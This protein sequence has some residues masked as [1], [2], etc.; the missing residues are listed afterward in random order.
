MVLR[1]TAPFRSAQARTG[2]SPLPASWTLTCLGPPENSSSTEVS[3]SVVVL[4][5]RPSESDSTSE[6]GY[7]ICSPCQRP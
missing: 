3:R 4:D 1:Y 7:S 6:W 2:G 5:P